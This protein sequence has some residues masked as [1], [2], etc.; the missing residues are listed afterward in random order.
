MPTYRVKVREL[1]EALYHVDAENPEGAFKAVEDGKGV[2]VDNSQEFVELAHPEMWCVMEE[3]GNPKFRRV[4]LAEILDKWL[5]EKFAQKADADQDDSEYVE[6]LDEL[7]HDL[8]S[9]S[10]SD[11]NNG[12]SIGQ[13]EFIVSLCGTGARKVIES[14]L[15]ED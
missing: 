11:A 7:I 5:T 13:I 15:G 4:L 1:H 12:G 6:L 10:G 2:L 3:A 8:A 9:S 14:A